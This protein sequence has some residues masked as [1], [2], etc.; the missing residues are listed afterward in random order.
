MIQEQADA[1]VNS[2]AILHVLSRFLEIIKR[3]HNSLACLLERCRVFTMCIPELL[4]ACILLCLFLED[5]DFVGAQFGR[6]TVVSSVQ[7]SHIQTHTIQFGVPQLAVARKVSAEETL[8]GE[9]RNNS[10]SLLRA[11]ENPKSASDNT[12][13]CTQTCKT[14]PATLAMPVLLL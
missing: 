11:R 1:Q 6:L 5:L 13:V 12:D 2:H 10:S 8:V 14:L 9:A 7:E 4:D 3:C